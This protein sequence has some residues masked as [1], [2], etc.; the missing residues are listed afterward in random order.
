MVKPPLLPPKKGAHI[1]KTAYHRSG[2]VENMQI[3]RVGFKIFLGFLALSSMLLVI[4]SVVVRTFY[5]SSLKRNEI[6]S[7]LQA[8]NR[9]TEQFDFIMGIIDGTA[10]IIGS[11]PEVLAALTSA[12]QPPPGQGDFSMNVYLQSLKEIQPF[13]GNI[14]I[15]GAGGQFYSSHVT[16][17]YEF[18]EDLYRRYEQYFY[19]G[20]Y[21]DYFVDTHN[22]G[23]FPPYA[24][25]DILTGVWPIYDIRAGKLLGQLYMGLNY[26]L[27]QELF[28]LSPTSNREK[29]LIVDPAGKIIYHYPAFI[30]FD[31]VLAGYPRLMTEDEAV[32]EGKVFGTDSVIVSETSRVVGWRFIRIVDIEHITGD[33]QRTQRFFNMVFIISIVFILIFSVLMAHTLTKPVK[34]LFDACRRIESGDLSFRVAVRSRDEMGQLG[35]TFNLVMDRINANLERELA[36][37]QRQNELKLE[38]LRSQISPHFLYNTLGSIKFLA[39]L[40][41]IHNIA[42]MCSDLINLLKYNLS[43]RTVATLGEEVESI[44]SYVNIQKYRYGDIFEFR[45]EIAAATEDCVISRFVLQPLVE[46]CLIHGFDAVESGG[47]IRIRSALDGDTLRLEVI[48]NGNR[49]DGKTLDRIN[50][51]AEQD[52]PSG[53]IGINNIRERIRLQFGDKATLMYAGGE[54]LETAAI[55]RFPVRREPPR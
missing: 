20:L 7:H 6:N 19:S 22:S 53:S 23:F 55:L 11:R 18:F 4:M 40:Q 54:G 39:N 38:V 46:N 37:Q 35:H 33:T 44:G 43:S 36:G 27:F 25:R 8:S 41:E 26:S 2:E 48:N 3:N 42:S 10:R 13:L 30:S 34:L 47:E 49:I 15:A 24:P 31:P 50:R 51:G 9:T 14:S 32:I 12:R 52:S 16:L 5:A 45:T 29:I 28:I 21:K 17:K 1:R